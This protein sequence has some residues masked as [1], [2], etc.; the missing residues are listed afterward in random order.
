MLLRVFRK[1]PQEDIRYTKLSDQNTREAILCKSVSISLT[2][3]LSYVMFT[4]F[5][6]K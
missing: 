2:Q 1:Y 4:E 6:R 5:F 3:A